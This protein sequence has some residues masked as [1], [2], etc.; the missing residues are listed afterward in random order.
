MPDRAQR[1]RPISAILRIRAQLRL[2][3]QAA[4]ELERVRRPKLSPRIPSLKPRMTI[5]DL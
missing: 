2:V 1:K 4:A 3:D 5:S